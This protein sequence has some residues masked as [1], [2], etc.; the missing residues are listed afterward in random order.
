MTYDPKDQEKR[1]S[2][3]TYNKICTMKGVIVTVP[4]QACE[5][6]NLVPEHTFKSKGGKNV[7]IKEHYKHGQLVGGVIVNRHFFGLT[8][9]DFGKRIVA[10]V[11]VII[12]KNGDKKFVML[13]IHKESDGAPINHRLVYRDKKT[14]GAGDIYIP[15]SGKLEPDSG[16]LELGSGMFLHFAPLPEP[17]KKPTQEG[18][19]PTP[20]QP[21]AT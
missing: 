8:P 4:T 13:N 5:Y 10:T 11:E 7:T 16:N 12:K 15:G 9:A 6:M 20:D 17:K 18:Q 1:K 2:E 19:M 21:Q 14:E 3:F